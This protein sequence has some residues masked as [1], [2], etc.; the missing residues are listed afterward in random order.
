MMPGEFMVPSVEAG[1]LIVTAMAVLL[2][3]ST[4][5]AVDP[6]KR[7]QVFRGWGTSLCWWANAVGGWEGKDVRAELMDLVFDPRKGL[8]LNIARYNIGGGENPKH[9]YMWDWRAIEGFRLEADGPYL[10]EADARQRW[11]LLESRK[12]GVNIVEAFANSPPWWMTI[13]GSCT[14]RCEQRPAANNLRDDM[15]PAC[16][17]YL[18]E[19]VREYRDRYGVVFDTLTPLN[20]PCAVWWT[21]GNNQEGCRFTVD[22]QQIILN[23]TAKQ[24]AAKGLTTKLSAPE[25]YSIDETVES[26]TTYDRETREAVYQINTHSYDGEGRAALCGIARDAG[27]PLFVTEYGN[28]IDGEFGSALE[29]ARVITLDLNELKCAGWVYWQAVGNSDH[30]NDWHAL[31]VSYKRQD[32]IVIRKQYWALLHFTRHVRPGSV[33]MDAP[34]G[35]AVI[36]LNP[37]GDL[38]IVAA[39]RGTAK[40]QVDVDLT[41]FPEL[42]KSA[43]WVVTTE[44]ESYAERGPVA[45]EG[46]SLSVTLCPRSIN[47]LVVSSVSRLESTGADR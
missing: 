40:R 44:E 25:E 7:G 23:E 43:R 30:P 29:L 19:V 15:Y 10:W 47:T 11:V 17:D 27:K 14:G 13:S 37:A 41:T 4:V 9:D 8:G 42:P 16:A 5:V 32:G 45:I 22:K 26:W 18:T 24:I 46:R 38:V 35:D 1:F 33:I 6:S 2:I 36:A 31:H 39:N 20:E 21:Q 12:R 3:A 34:V 28:G